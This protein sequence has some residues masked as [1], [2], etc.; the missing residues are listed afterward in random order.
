M[1]ARLRSPLPRP[2]SAA[3]VRGHQWVNQAV[4]LRG[5]NDTAEDVAE[6]MNR[7]LG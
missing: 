5:V 2:L 4:L 6:L 3:H 1:R 7:L